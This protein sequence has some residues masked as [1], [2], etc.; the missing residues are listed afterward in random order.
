MNCKKKISVKM[1]GKWEKEKGYRK[2]K[3]NRMM[4][5]LNLNISITFILM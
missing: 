5:D 4:I 2:Q 1:P 3:T